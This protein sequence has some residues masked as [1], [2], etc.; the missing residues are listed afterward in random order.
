[1]N[2]LDAGRI[3][4]SIGSGVRP[5]LESLDVFAVLD[6]TN[7][8]LM[9]QAPPRPG[10]S[11]AALAE[12][13]TAGKGRMGR[14]WQSPPSS[15]ICLSL[16]YTFRRPEDAT[17]CLTLAA[18]IGL[19]ELLDESGVRG[20][21]L[22]WPNDLVVRDAKLGG[23]LTECRSGASH[24][25]SVVVG[26]GI[27]VDLSGAL[28]DGAPDSGSGPVIDLAS[29][30]DDLPSRTDLSARLIERLF[31]T[32]AEFDADGFARFHTAW[33]DYDWLR[34]RRIRVNT[35]ACVETGLC[36]GIDSKGALLL[37]TA[38]GRTAISSGSIRFDGLA[39][40]RAS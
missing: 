31:E 33:P 26:V 30:C 39:G 5:H 16:S 2:F 10:R 19:A 32:M 37:R 15:G 22:K 27:N 12:Y 6:S 35:G 18:G 40:C 8:Y 24:G 34:G 21:G 11:R 1:M 20:I 13:Q 9:S 36:E 25:V 14:R 3:R 4:E 7:T 28:P 29:C 23:I 38:G 17:S